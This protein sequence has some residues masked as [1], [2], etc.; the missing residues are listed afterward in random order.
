MGRWCGRWAG[1]AGDG[2]VVREMGRWCGRWA[3]GVRDKNN[4]GYTVTV[5]NCHNMFTTVI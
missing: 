4:N 5:K 3:G 2:Q 1:G